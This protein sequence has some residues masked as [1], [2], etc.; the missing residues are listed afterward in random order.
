MFVCLLVWSG[1]LGY[2]AWCVE[3]RQ[4]DGGRGGA[5]EMRRVGG[6]GEQ[7]MQTS[8]RGDERPAEKLPGKA[9]RQIHTGPRIRATK[10]DRCL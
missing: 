2:P 9:A 3:E 7:D 10:T 5:G 6:G 8:P 4:P 1:T